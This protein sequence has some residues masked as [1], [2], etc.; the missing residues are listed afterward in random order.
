MQQKT[1]GVT[2]GY[3]LLPFQGVLYVTY[4][5]PSYELLPFQGV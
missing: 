4:G 3:G 1:Q 5:T 2:L